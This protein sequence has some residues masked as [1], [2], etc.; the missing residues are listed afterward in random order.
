MEAE[1]F[2]EGRRRDGQPDVHTDMTNLVDAFCSFANAPESQFNL[3][4][5]NVFG[6]RDKSDGIGK[7]WIFYLCFLSAAC[8]ETLQFPYL[9]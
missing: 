9:H 4:V 7:V 6:F 5:V 3:V 2:H 8:L 1:L